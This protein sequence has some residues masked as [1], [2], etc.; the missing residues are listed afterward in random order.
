MKVMGSSIDGSQNVYSW[1]GSVVHANNVDISHGCLFK[2][3]L[4]EFSNG[5]GN[6]V[7]VVGL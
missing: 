1:C 3:V 4:I 5:L 6:D 7:D 2:T